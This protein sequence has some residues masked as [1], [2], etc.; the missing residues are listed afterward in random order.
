MDKKDL[1][2]IM[3]KIA[4]IY[5]YLDKKNSEEKKAIINAYFEEL[6]EYSCE[7]VLDAIDNLSL[8]NKY[9]PSVAEIRIQIK[10]NE[11][12]S[13]WNNANLNSCYWYEIEREWCEENNRPYYDI[14]KGPDYPLPP[15]KHWKD[16]QR[17]EE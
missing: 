7:Q 13:T 9:V 4:N 10:D 2:K 16:Y 6:K 11:E 8:K 3:S 1:P 15:F 14:T 12:Y 5:G 17:E